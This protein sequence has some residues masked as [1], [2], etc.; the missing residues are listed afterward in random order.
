[1]DGDRKGC[2]ELLQSHGA[3]LH[4]NPLNWMHADTDKNTHISPFLN[5]TFFNQAM[6]T[7]DEA[8]IIKVETHLKTYTRDQ[9]FKY[10]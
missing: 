2:L 7:I 1:M 8:L 4:K 5:E 10:D 6:L 9:K 3:D